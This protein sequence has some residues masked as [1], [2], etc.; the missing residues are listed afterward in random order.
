MPRLVPAVTLLVIA[1]FAA[2]S[3]AQPGPGEKGQRPAN[4]G[5]PQKPG[6]RP[7][8]RPRPQGISPEQI[9]ARLMQEF[10][11]DNDQKLNTKELAALLTSM[12]Q[13]RGGMRP[14]GNPP[15]GRPGQPGPR[16]RPQRPAGDKPGRPGGQAPKRPAAE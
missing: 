5:G 6:A 4:A 8:G 3:L 12:R 15:N 16:N 14:G 13:R 7:Q 10:D 11:K 9:A 1:L 2:P